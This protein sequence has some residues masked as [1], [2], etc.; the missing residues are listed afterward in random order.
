MCPCCSIYTDFLA[1]LKPGVKLLAMMDCCHSGSM[2]EQVFNTTV[3]SKLK[4]GGCCV[5]F[6]A[7]ALA[8]VEGRLLRVSR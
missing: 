6:M 7:D 8:F 5:P 1:L 4:P 2:L 3:T